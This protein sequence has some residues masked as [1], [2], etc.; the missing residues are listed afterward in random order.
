MTKEELL[1]NLDSGILEHY[2]LCD[3]ALE[4]IEV[5]ETEGKTYDQM[6]AQFILWDELMEEE[7]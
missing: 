1:E 5:M 3:G 2:Y 6:W 7:Q 4:D